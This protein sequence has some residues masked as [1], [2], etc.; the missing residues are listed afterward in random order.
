MRHDLK[1]FHFYELECETMAYDWGRSG[2]DALLHQLAAARGGASDPRTP[3]AELWMGAHRK[4]PARLPQHQARSLA[5]LIAE[6]PEH[7]LGAELSQR[8]VTALPFLFKVLDAAEPL[9]IQ[10][11]PDKALAEQLHARDPANYPD[12]NHKPELAICLNGMTALCGFRPVRE[13]E[14]FLRTR[15]ELPGLTSASGEIYEGDAAYRAGGDDGSPAARA[16]MKERYGRLMRSSPHEIQEAVR[17]L[18]LRAETLWEESELPETERLFLKLVQRFGERDPGLFCVYFLNYIELAPGEALFL[19][20]NEPH[21]YLSGAILECMAASDNVVRAGLTPKFVDVDALIEMLHYGS[22]RPRILHPEPIAQGVA[23]YRTPAREFEVRRLDLSQPLR[24]AG[25]ARPAILIDLEH[26]FRLEVADSDAVLDGADVL[27]GAPV[28]LPGDL[29][30]R[31]LE[32]RLSAR[33]AHS[34]YLATI[35]PEF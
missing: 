29:A 11:H 15:P 7:F 30:G 3:A 19:G 25:V 14:E 12:D 10:A 18:R 6:D 20:P 22:G 17:S 4:A 16:W 21:A 35:S 28:L 32:V 27:R 1:H 9:S 33:Q 8:G 5:D 23:R 24:L 34:L 26:A 2:P 13:I 31:G